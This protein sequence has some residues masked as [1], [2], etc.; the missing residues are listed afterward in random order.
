MGARTKVT[1]GICLRSGDGEWLLARYLPVGASAKTGKAGEKCHIPGKKGDVQKL[2]ASDTLKQFRRAVTATKDLQVQEEDVLMISAADLTTLDKAKS[3][4]ELL[5]E[6]L[7]SLDDAEME[8]LIDAA[9]P[10]LSDRPAS[11]VIDQARRN[12]GARAK[13]VKAYEMLDAEQVHELFGSAAKNRAA[14]AARWRS[15]GKIFAL[16]YR[17]RLLYPAFQFDRQGRPKDIIGKVLVMLGD[18]AGP[19]QTAIWFT[20]ANGW[21]DGKR[22]LDL[23]DSEP[24]RVLDAA[25]DITE[26]VAH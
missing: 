13:F 20:S 23:L 7:H 6:R 2:S 9:M 12:A 19:W 5:G 24:D 1:K 26:P 25:A 10:T 22:P 16:D 3:L 17:G 18:A 15:D 8:R 21:L 4:I 14:L 11:T